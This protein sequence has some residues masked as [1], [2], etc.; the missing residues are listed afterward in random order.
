MSRKSL[1]YSLEI[2]ESSD[3][4][5]KLLQSKQ[6][7]VLIHNRIKF[8]WLLKTKTCSTQSSAG[9]EI[10]LKARQSQ[11]LWSLYKKNGFESFISNPHKG[12]NNARLST[13]QDLALLERLDKDDM[14]VQRE[15]V[16]FISQTFQVKYSLPGISLKLRRLKVKLKT[17]RPV[18]VRK[19]EQG[20]VDF[21]K[22]QMN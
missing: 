19:D 13:E 16:A 1:N 11:I 15:I 3:T 10:G 18:N 12:G 7:S 20:A 14:I 9:L 8:L 21:K 17:G 2:V 4:L 6:L 22:K 5:N